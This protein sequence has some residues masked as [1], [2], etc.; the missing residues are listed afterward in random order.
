MTLKI[1]KAEERVKKKEKDL[2]NKGGYKGR[3]VEK[4]K[5]IKNQQR[6]KYFPTRL[7]ASKRYFPKCPNRNYLAT[8]SVSYWNLNKCPE[9]LISI[10][11]SGYIS[12]YKLVSRIYERTWTYFS[13]L[14]ALYV[15]NN[16]T[17]Q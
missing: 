11:M 4:G 16:T 14:C 6:E 12:I 3:K 5:T 17:K 8:K 13:R 15:L 1:I 2:E 10:H 7:N 9:G